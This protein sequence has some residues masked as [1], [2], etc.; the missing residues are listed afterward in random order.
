MSSIL[1]A[2]EPSR[3]GPA[4]GEMMC[5]PTCRATQ[6]WSPTCRRCKCDLSL[7]RMVADEYRESRLRC[8]QELRWGRHQAALDHARQCLRLDAK[9]ESQRLFAVC[10]LLARDWPSALA[11]ARR[12][13][14]DE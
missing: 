7:L 9:G 13:M 3:S 11:T 8:L 2:S 6:E 12:I 4:A 1:P 10:A 14:A 5:C